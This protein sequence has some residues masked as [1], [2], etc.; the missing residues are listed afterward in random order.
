MDAFPHRYRVDAQG[1]LEGPVEVK[2]AGASPMNTYPPP[3]FG[4]PSG[5][6]SPESLLV[7]AVADCY[8]FT[9]R[10]IARA[11]KLSW[12]ELRC[13]A[14]GE[15]DRVE[16]QPYFTKLKLVAKLSVPADVD[17]EKAKRLLEKSEKRCLVTASLR[18]EVE[19]VTEIVVQ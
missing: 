12:S 11:S 15:L 2:V 5:E 14:T 4:G 1:S 6:W 16:K 7:A 17:P 10:A 3:Q 18:S 19:L 9:F 13:E 8:I